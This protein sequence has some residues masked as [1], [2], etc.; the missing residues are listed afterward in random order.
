M[1][2]AGVLVLIVEED[3]VARRVPQMG[4]RLRLR[5]NLVP[6]RLLVRRR[7]WQLLV[8]R[9]PTAAGEDPGLA[10]EALGQRRRLVLLQLLGL[11]LLGQ[12]LPPG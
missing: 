8:L 5:R 9:R 1:G 10:K 2:G 6:L 7:R 12:L 4:R 3:D 11:V